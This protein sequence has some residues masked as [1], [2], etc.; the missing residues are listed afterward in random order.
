MNWFLVI[1]DTNCKKDLDAFLKKHEGSI[2][3][4][5]EADHAFRNIGR[6]MDDF[7]LRSAAD[8]RISINAASSVNV[9]KVADIV[10]CESQRS[11]TCI[12]LSNG[13]KLTVTKTLKQFEAELK[14]YDFARIHQSH[15]VNL[16]HVV[17]Y[18]KSKGGHVVLSDG[19]EIPVAVRKKELLFREL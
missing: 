5:N 14:Q 18:V 19:R 3:F 7:T 9:L 8:A 13:N 6:L 12:Y 10:H 17:K 11:Y 2:V 4:K 15:L 16:N 1:N